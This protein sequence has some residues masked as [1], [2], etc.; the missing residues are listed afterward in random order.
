MC[1][2]YGWTFARMITRIAAHGVAITIHVVEAR[3][4][5]P[6]FVKMDAIDTGGQ[7]IL[8]NLRLLAHTV[9]C[10]IGDHRIS[11][12]ARDGHG[13]HD[14]GCSDVPGY[15]LRRKLRGRIR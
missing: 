15:G 1:R 12:A 9:V 10:A 6:G 5:I 3:V 13:S 11:R 7:K 4:A 14:R 2:K 8:R